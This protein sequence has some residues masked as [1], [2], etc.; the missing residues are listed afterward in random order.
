MT[1]DDTTEATEPTDDARLDRLEQTQAEQG[2]ALERIETMLARIVPGSHAEAEERTEH[3]LDRPSDL[4][5]AVQ[6]ELAR[7][8]Q[9]KAD[10]ADRDAE[11]SEREEMR[12]L[13]AKLKEVPPAPPRNP[14]KELATKGWGG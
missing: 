5:E 7:A 13:A 4:K 1:A 14:L 6:A 11:K 12:A 9:A 3:R 10:A 2:S 8:E